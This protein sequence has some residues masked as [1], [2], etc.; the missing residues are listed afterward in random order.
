MT[1]FIELA[2]FLGIATLSAI[3]AVAVL[4]GLLVRDIELKDEEENFVFT[5]D[6]EKIKFNIKFDEE[7]KK[8][9]IDVVTDSFGNELKLCDA[10]PYITDALYDLVLEAQ[11]KN[12]MR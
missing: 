11:K 1:Q 2:A 4:L 9:D 8:V 10:M 7:T 5:K 6:G 12:M 3:F